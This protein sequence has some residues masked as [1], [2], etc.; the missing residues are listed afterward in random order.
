M[1]AKLIAFIRGR[2]MRKGFEQ[3]EAHTRA[4]TKLTANYERRRRREIARAQAM[5]REAQG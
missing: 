2:H 5:F 4:S 3:L 1:I